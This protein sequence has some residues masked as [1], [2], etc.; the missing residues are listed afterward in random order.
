[1]STHAGADALHA[2]ARDAIA[3]G[4]GDRAV[5]L[6]ERAAAAAP[7]SVEVLVDLGR[8]LVA[9]ERFADA[10]SALRKAIRAARDAPAPRLLLA[11]A[12]TRQSKLDE[13]ATQLKKLLERH[14]AHADAWFNLGNVHRARGALED[15]ARCFGR[16]AAL[17]PGN[18]DAAINLGLVLAHGERLDDAASALERFLAQGKP[19]PDVLLNL[20]QVRRAL[21]LQDSAREAFETALQLAPDHLGARVNRAIALAEGGL[22]GAAEDEA[23]AIIASQPDCAEAHFLLATICLATGRFEEGWREYRWRPD[24]MRA[25]GNAPLPPIERLRGAPVTVRGE[26]GIGDALFFLRYLPALREIA[27]SVR[28]DVDP[29]LVAILPPEWAAGANQGSSADAVSVMAGDLPA[30][31]GPDPAPSLALSPDSQRVAAL[32]TRLASAGPPPYVGV[33]WEAGTRLGAQ[34]R[35]GEALFKRVDP[36]RLGRV[37]AGLPGTAV[38][39]Q[40]NPRPVDLA[41]FRRGLGRAPGDCSDTNADLEDGLAVLAVLDNYVGV[42]NANMHLRAAVGRAAQ[43]LVTRPPEWRWMARGDRSPWF[44]DFVLYRQTGA[45]WDEAFTDLANDLHAASAG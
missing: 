11:F 25:L 16:A 44:P 15:A 22:E 3:Q 18:P 20:G 2:A 13:A 41:A 24:R 45:G 10:E 26:Q 33:T 7:A 39:L 27:G 35:P 12:L 14:P 38:V 4:D 8:L 36:E 32:K 37:L 43:V 30:L 34:S 1:M 9:A 29:R 5:A 19:H 21:G 17:Q 31:V 6:L 40:R 42:S 28:L 23:R